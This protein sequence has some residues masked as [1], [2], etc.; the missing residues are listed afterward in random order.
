MA[1]RLRRCKMELVLAWE[2]QH[3]LAVATKVFANPLSSYKHK[4][5]LLDMLL[6]L[7]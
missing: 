2:H 4:D 5:D 3:M 6:P 1:E 7:V